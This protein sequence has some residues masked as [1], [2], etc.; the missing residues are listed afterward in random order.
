MAGLEL[1]KLN[2]KGRLLMATWHHNTK[3]KPYDQDYMDGTFIQNLI[4]DNVKVGF[5]GHQHKLEIIREENN[6][7]DNKAMLVLSSGSLCAGP[8]EIPAGYNQQYNIL[9]LSRVGDEEIELRALSRVKT[10]DS[11][12]D[13]PIWDT[14]TINS[15]S[16]E[17]KSKIRHFLPPSPSLGVIESLI[18]NKEYVNAFNALLQLDL[19][20]V[21]VRIFL[22]ECCEKLDDVAAIANYFIVPINNTEAIALLNACM[23]LRDKTL[24]QTVLENEYIKTSKDPSVLHF[25]SQLERKL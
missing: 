8:A 14:G 7:V 16:T 21:I 9:E 24:S 1:R 23:D 19:D 20:D 2:K 15:T 13:N 10:P 6:I 18:G 22:L 12:Y 5:H 25:R 3:G 4:A 17:Y 11:S